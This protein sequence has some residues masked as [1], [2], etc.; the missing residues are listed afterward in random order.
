MI[1]L[2]DK[3]KVCQKCGHIMKEVLETVTYKIKYIPAKLL[4]PLFNLMYEDI[5]KFDI[6]HMD[7][8]TLQ[9]I[10]S[11]NNQS[12]MWGLFSFKYNTP[13]KL[14][15]YKDNRRHENAKEILKDFKGYL[16]IDAYKAYD[17]VDDA[18]NINCFAHARRQY[19]DLIK[20]F[21][22]NDGKITKPL[23]KQSLAYID[24]LYKVEHQLEAE[25][26]S[27][28]DIYQT[29]NTKSKDILAK[30]K[31]WLNENYPTVPRNSLIAKAMAYSINPFDNLSNYLLDALPMIGDDVDN[32][33]KLLPYSA[34]L[35]ERVKVKK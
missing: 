8:K 7:E 2:T 9:V 6:V 31:K 20:V 18:I 24:A 13:I 23:A 22:D 17:K 4:E 10:K 11:C 30:Y 32:L 29:R 5:L 34:E 3:E 16:I 26:A 1:D 15:F 27:I 33:R 28:N 25:K 12:Y 14:Y 19:V 35:P 21:K